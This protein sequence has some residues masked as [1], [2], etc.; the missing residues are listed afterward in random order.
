MRILVVCP[1][2]IQPEFGAAQIHLNL[3]AALRGLGHSVLLWS[4]YPLSRE[5]HWTA[6]LLEVRGKLDALLRSGEEFDVI[7]CPP[8]LVGLARVRFARARVTWVARSVQ[9]DLRYIW[10]GLRAQISVRSSDIAGTAALAVWSAG[11]GALVCAG[12]R[13]S[14]VVMCFGSAERSWM[15]GRFPRLRSKLRSYDGAISDEDRVK[16]A[17]V[18]AERAVRRYDDPVRYIWIGRWSAHKGITTLL[19]FL[20][21]RIDAGTND[22]FTIAGC[23]AD[24]ERALAPLASSGRIHVIPTFSR[25]DLPGLLAAHDAGLFTS[26]V[27]GWG[28]VLHEMVESGIPIYATTAG[29]VADIRGM[30]GSFVGDFPPRPGARLPAPPTDEVFA[31]Y[32]ARFRWS[33]IAARYIESISPPP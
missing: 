33:A 29:G 20:R 28:L 12:W 4:P 1:C 26:H 25:I 2:P 14:D 5:M 21:D 15:A 22:T 24:G 17:R 13:A 30:L 18:R 11:V 6:E 32:E 19:R 3:A 9:P 23:A 31:E 8:H 27:E 16:L 10:A 7:D